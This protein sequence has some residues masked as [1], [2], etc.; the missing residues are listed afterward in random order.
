[1]GRKRL[2]KEIS[3]KEFVKQVLMNGGVKTNELCAVTWRQ[4]YAT[5]LNRQVEIPKKLLT[6]TKV[7]HG[8][9]DLTK[10]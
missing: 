4:L 2:F 7:R 9:Y 5:K 3:E 1:M 10:L 8:I 6:V